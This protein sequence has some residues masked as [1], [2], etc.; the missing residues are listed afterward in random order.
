MRRAVGISCAAALAA[1]AVLSGGAA[2]ARNPKVVFPS[3]PEDRAAF[4]YAAMTKEDCFVELDARGVPWTHG[5]ERGLV[6][7]PVVLAGALRGV[8]LEHQYEPERGQQD[9]PLMDCRLLVAVDDFAQVAEELGFSVIRYNSIYRRCC[10]RRAGRRH[11]SALA[12]DVTELVRNDGS[13]L[14]VRRDFHGNGIGSYTCGDR[15]MPVA[16]PEG[17]ALHEL[18]C[19]LDERGSF[20]LMLTP[21]YDYRHRDHFHFEVRREIEWYL[22]Q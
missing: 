3:E 13:V 12:L 7:A 15:A 14:N 11:P 22:T 9:E 6:E 16:E 2:D 19:A 18:I 10:A 17:R 21:N 1:A 20:N 8:R 4:R 5:E